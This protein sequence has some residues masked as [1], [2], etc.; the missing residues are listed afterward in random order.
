MGHMATSQ[1]F[2]FSK[3]LWGWGALN[4]VVLGMLR[5]PRALIIKWP[6][7]GGDNL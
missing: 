1:C 7:S 2:V 3:A 6:L 5:E 4:L